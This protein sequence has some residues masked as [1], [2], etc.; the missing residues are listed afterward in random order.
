MSLG[1][2]RD[3]VIYPDSQE[4]M[5]SR[6]VSDTHLEA[7]L[8]TVHLKYI[9]KRE[10]GTYFCKRTTC[11]VLNFV[12]TIIFTIRLLRFLFS[13]YKIMIIIY[14]IIVIC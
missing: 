3:Q 9:I 8:D 2:L 7:V 4:D 11:I 10:G 5:E 6:G 13:T 14:C 1:T 12:G